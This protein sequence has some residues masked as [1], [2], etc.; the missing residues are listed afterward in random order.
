MYPCGTVLRFFPKAT[1]THT[2]TRERAGT[3]KRSEAS[4]SESQLRTSESP[5][6]RFSDAPVLAKSESPSVNERTKRDP[7]LPSRWPSEA[8]R[9]GGGNPLAPLLSCSFYLAYVQREMG[10]FFSIFA[11]VLRSSY[12][13]RTGPSHPRFVFCVRLVLF[14]FTIWIGSGLHLDV[15]FGPSSSVRALRRRVCRHAPQNT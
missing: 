8:R 5:W 2:H 11:I 3:V 1:S 10:F 13:S 7:R 15:I 12:R 9:R 14:F 6:I 4:C